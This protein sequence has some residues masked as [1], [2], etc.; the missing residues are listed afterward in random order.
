MDG[1][2]IRLVL[3]LAGGA[4]VVLAN[5]LFI[6]PEFR[7]KILDARIYHTDSTWRHRR[8]ALLNLRFHVRL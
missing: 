6:R 5:G 8:L 1:H 7:L 4:T 2:T 3:Q